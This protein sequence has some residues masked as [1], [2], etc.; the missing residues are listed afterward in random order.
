MVVKWREWRRR[1]R[2]VRELVNPADE[3]RKVCRQTILA[4]MA[5]ISVLE[6]Q[7][8]ALRKEQKEAAAR[9]ADDIRNLELTAKPFKLWEG[10]HWSVDH[11]VTV[12]SEL[13]QELTALRQAA[14]AFA[15]R[16]LPRSGGKNADQRRLAA[17]AAC[18]LIAKFSR[19]PL[20]KWT[21]AQMRQVAAAL[22][23]E[24]VEK[25]EDGTGRSSWDRYFHHSAKQGR[26]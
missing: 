24:K 13:L 20:K 4:A 11:G 10:E 8:K 3:D 15:N 18:S 17:E 9:L 5:E 19:R 26:K 22:V 12:T 16:P 6:I 1:V 25:F 14:E 2:Q 7:N 21:V 23:G